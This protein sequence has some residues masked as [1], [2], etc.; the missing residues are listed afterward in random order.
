MWARRGCAAPEGCV[1]CEAGSV[2]WTCARTA[3]Q[4]GLDR[5]R[6]R[7][8]GHVRGAMNADCEGTPR[9]QVCGRWVV[10]GAST[11]KAL[12]AHA[13]QGRGEAGCEEAGMDRARPL[14]TQR[15]VAVVV[16][17]CT[18][19]VERSDRTS[20]GFLCRSRFGSA[21]VSCPRLRFC[22]LPSLRRLRFQYLRMFVMMRISLR[23]T[24]S[25]ATGR[26][27]ARRGVAHKRSSTG[28]ISQ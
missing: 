11:S 6:S 14:S 8:P 17:V 4:A 20:E 19:C 9:R 10:K 26:T 25:G 18:G 16:T 12:H 13:R 23:K 28:P 27:L 21:R 3:G 1:E 22:V 24:D 5:A 2:G 15:G 7:P